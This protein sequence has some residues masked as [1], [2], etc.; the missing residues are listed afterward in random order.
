[1]KNS[2][3]DTSVRIFLRILLF[4][5][6]ILYLWTLEVNSCFPASLKRGKEVLVVWSTNF[7]IK[8]P[9]GALK[10]A[11]RRAIRTEIISTDMRAIRVMFSYY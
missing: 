10:R 9:A 1:M 7:T 11:L 2:E 5:T 8:R 4:Y 6:Y 3:S